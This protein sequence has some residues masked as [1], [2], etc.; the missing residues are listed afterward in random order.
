M[1][2]SGNGPIQVQYFAECVLRGV[3]G[4]QDFND[5]V[6]NIKMGWTWFQLDFQ[7]SS[8]RVKRVL[9]VDA[10]FDATGIYFVIHPPES[11]WIEDKIVR[12][13]DSKNLLALDVDNIHASDV[14]RWVEQNM[15]LDAVV[16]EITEHIDWMIENF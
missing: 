15:D 6:S 11:P 5:R 2:T 9:T 10:K 12:V 14:Q 4:Y 16:E 7:P 8:K 3:K 13:S 1:F